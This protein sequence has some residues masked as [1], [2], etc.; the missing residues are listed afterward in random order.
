MY[1]RTFTK[2]V[3]VLA[4]SVDV[5]QLNPVV[6]SLKP[7]YNI[8][9]HLIS[10][11]ADY[12]EKYLERKPVSV[13]S[14]P[15][16]LL[17][18]GYKFKKR[19]TLS[20]MYIKAYDR[21]N[22]EFQIINAANPIKNNSLSDN[23][24]GNKSINAIPSNNNQTSM[25][26]NTLKHHNYGKR[27][28]I[29]IL[30][31][32]MEYNA[33][34]T[35]AYDE[36][37]NL[38]NLEWEPVAYEGFD[39][40]PPNVY[41]T[42]HIAKTTPIFWESLHYDGVDDL[43][44]KAT[45]DSDIK[46]INYVPDS[47]N[48]S[49][50]KSPKIQLNVKVDN[51]HLVTEKTRKFEEISKEVQRGSNE[52]DEDD[53]E[54]FKHGSVKK[55][56]TQEMNTSTKSTVELKQ[57]TDDSNSKES[58]DLESIV[59]STLNTTN[60]SN[61]NEEREIVKPSRI[62]SIESQGDFDIIEFLNPTT[63]GD[64]ESQLNDLKTDLLHNKVEQ[65]IPQSD[66]V[67]ERVDLL[68]NT[69]EVLQPKTLDTKDIAINFKTNVQ[70]N[71]TVGSTT[72][73]FRPFRTTYNSLF[74]ELFP[75]MNDTSAN[76]NLSILFKND[77][78]IS[79]KSDIFFNDLLLENNQNDIA[80]ISK[81]YTTNNIPTLTVNSPRFT[82]AAKVIKKF[83]PVL[84][85][86]I[87]V[88]HINRTNPEKE[89]KEANSIEETQSTFVTDF[90]HVSRLVYKYK[91]S[92]TTTKRIETNTESVRRHT[93]PVIDY[94]YLL[95]SQLSENTPVPVKLKKTTREHFSV[96]NINPEHDGKYEWN[97]YNNYDEVLSNE[98]TEISKW[99]KV[100]P[101]QLPEKKG[102]TNFIS[103][104]T[105]LSSLG[106]YYTLHEKPKR[107]TYPTMFT[108]QRSTSTNVT[109]RRIFHLK[110]RRNTTYPNFNNTIKK[111]SAIDDGDEILDSHHW[112]DDHGTDD[113]EFLERPVTDP[114]ILQPR[115]IYSEI[116]NDPYQKQ[117]QVHKRNIKSTLFD[118]LFKTQNISHLV[119]IIWHKNS[120]DEVYKNV[121]QRI[122]Y[123]LGRQKREC[124]P[125]DATFVNAKAFVV[126]TGTRTQNNCFKNIVTNDDDNVTPYEHN[127]ITT[128][129]NSLH[130]VSNMATTEY[131]LIKQKKQLTTVE[132]FTENVESEKIYSG[133]KPLLPKLLL[134]EKQPMSKHAKYKKKSQVKL[135]NIWRFMANSNMIHT[136]P[137]SDDDHISYKTNHT[138]LLVAKAQVTEGNRF[139]IVKHESKEIV[140]TTTIGPVLSFIKN[141][142]DA[143]ASN[144]DSAEIIHIPSKYL[145]IEKLCE[146]TTGTDKLSQN[147]ITVPAALI[148]FTQKPTNTFFKK[149][150]TAAAT[151]YKL[152]KELTFIENVTEGTPLKQWTP[153]FM[154]ITQQLNL[155]SPS[156]TK[157]S[158]LTNEVDAND[159]GTQHFNLKK[160]LRTTNQPETIS[161]IPPDL[162]DPPPKNYLY[163]KRVGA[164][165]ITTAKI[166]N[167]TIKPKKRLSSVKRNQFS[168][169]SLSS[170][171]PPYSFVTDW[172]KTKTNMF[173]NV[174]EKRYL[175]FFSKLSKK[176]NKKENL[177]TTNQKKPIPSG[178]FNKLRQPDENSKIATKENTGIFEFNLAKLHVPSNFTKN[179]VPSATESNVASTF[180]KFN[181]LNTTSLPVG[182]NAAIKENTTK[183]TI[184]IKKE[185]PTTLYSA[186]D[187]P[188]RE[189]SKSS[190]EFKNT[191][192]TITPILN[193]D[194]TKHWIYGL[195]KKYPV[196]VPGFDNRHYLPFTKGISKESKIFKHWKS[197]H[198]PW[199]LHFWNKL[200]EDHQ[201]LSLFPA[202]LKY[203]KLES[204]TE[205]AVV[206]FYFKKSI[207]LYTNEMR[208]T[209]KVPTL[210]EIKR[211]RVVPL[212]TV[213]NE[214]LKNTESKP[215]LKSYISTSKVHRRLTK[216]P[217]IKTN[218]RVLLREEARAKQMD[219]YILYMMKKTTTDNSND[220]STDW[221]A[222]DEDRWP[223]TLLKS[224]IDY[225]KL[226]ARDEF[227][228]YQDLMENVDNEE[229]ELEVKTLSKKSRRDLDET[230]NTIISNGID[231]NQD[232]KT[233]GS[234]EQ[235]EQR[236]LDDVDKLLQHYFPSS[237]TWKF[238]H[239]TAKTTAATT[240]LSPSLL[241]IINKSTAPR[242]QKWRLHAVTQND[243]YQSKR[244]VG[245]IGRPRRNIIKRILKKNP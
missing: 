54:V 218:D 67:L 80:F 150:Y 47:I 178:I 7:Q 53:I 157:L 143:R 52:E 95:F 200:H 132:K 144:H 224:L 87:L 60:I 146:P 115:E 238:I 121:L 104:Y 26:N 76:K 237:K 127:V 69:G 185:L 9:N 74:N 179:Y 44:H 73:E 135:G 156:E 166:A 216:E 207:N 37:S 123:R 96:L 211:I 122:K 168:T 2:R 6:E 245:L 89:S 65:A 136:T 235:K 240:L 148:D 88:H 180:N 130:E 209:V 79:E 32:D 39:S 145:P 190:D 223:P 227:P 16:K 82:E 232:N 119:T 171:A 91:Q 109:S 241:K 139:S 33:L 126:E 131:P 234:A 242:K 196:I 85:Q 93:M 152:A 118:E 124:K 61:T 45:M 142:T 49:S 173:K 29:K 36:M 4:D 239:Y 114:G 56:G 203:R 244:R 161:L 229:Q 225:N 153:F 38:K 13:K 27:R 94:D 217:L 204:T 243:K 189:T 222:F 220:E 97:D 195:V 12:D 199:V 176:Y 192:L 160:V 147:T 149:I 86:K 151:P 98:D 140:T 172:A 158:L 92:L 113:Y 35:N 17:D 120:S 159:Y 226:D 83:L 177:S 110:I 41:S 57:I 174:T 108:T 163:F 10:V 175:S 71:T 62:D 215:T 50:E 90:G 236:L 193:K 107:T 134:K 167:N 186:T 116:I 231:V 75:I 101:L 103:L 212:G 228:V 77:S 55:N 182:L 23:N 188:T 210:P 68:D 154:Y 208:P 181:L 99:Q 191:L 66:E 1:P 129:A 72:T 28:K 18:T 184:E 100:I 162:F 219:E 169:I 197:D 183:R 64:Q 221:P 30:Y 21:I 164:T 3:E 84:K 58:L 59:L 48:T 198:P 81:S 133:V 51:I 125:I 14:R 194:K 25:N 128:T 19:F 43:T 230:H 205:D 31:D 63:N 46:K 42:Q 165:M 11:T 214:I 155:K 202:K 78:F 138:T 206:N 34:T 111:T 170:L 22:N 137:Q 24:H 20:D 8:G 70:P 117:A 102:T 141:I 106:N 40:I 105:R 233:E 187:N 112:T 213:D 15:A 201:T 5:E